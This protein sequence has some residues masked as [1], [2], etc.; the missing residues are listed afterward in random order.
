[1]TVERGAQPGAAASYEK[2]IHNL[3]VQAEL[4]RGAK[5]QQSQEIESFDTPQAL[6]TAV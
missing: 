3:A 1:L 6:A 4:Q 2:K 5:L